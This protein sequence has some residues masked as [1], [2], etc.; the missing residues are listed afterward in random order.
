MRFDIPQVLEVLQVVGLLAVN[1]PQAS[2]VSHPAAAAEQLMTWTL[3]WTVMR[4]SVA[5][6]R[7]VDVALRACLR[8]F[9]NFMLIS[10]CFRVFGA[11]AFM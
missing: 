1:L 2:Q 5:G 9:H 8:C 4:E 3:I 6:A 10:V 11:P 7:S